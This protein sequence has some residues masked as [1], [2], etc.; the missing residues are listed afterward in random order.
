M[1]ALAVG[2]TAASTLPPPRTARCTRWTPR[3]SRAPSS[4]PARSTSGPSP[5]TRQATCSWPPAREGRIYR[6]DPKGKAQIVLTSPE[7]HILSLAIDDRGNLY[8]GSAPEGIVYRLDP[9]LK[10]FVLLDSRLPRDQGPRDGQ[11]TAAST[12]PPWTRRARTRRRARPAPGG[13]RPGACPGGRGDRHGD[14]RD[15]ACPTAPSGAAARTT[16][17]AP[18]RGRGQGSGPAHPAY[19]RGRHSLVLRGRDAARPRPLGR[20][21]PAGHRQQGQALPGARR[22]HLDHADGAARGA[23]DGARPQP[24]A[25]PSLV[26]TSNPGKLHVDRGRLRRRGGRSPRRSRT[27]RR[28]PCGAAC[29][30]RPRC[31]RGREVQVQTPQRQHRD[32]GLHLDRLVG[33]LPAQRRRCRHQRARALPAD[34]GHARPERTAPRPVLDSVTAAYLQRNLRPQVQSITVHAPGEVFQKPISISGETEI[35]GLEGSP[36]P[37]R[38]GAAAARAQHASGH[39]LQPEAV[40]ARH[41]DVLLEGRRPERRHP[42]LRRVLPGGRAIARSGSLRKGLTDAVL[43]WDTSTVPNGRY[44]IRVTASDSPSNPGRPGPRGRQGEP[45]LRG[46]QHAAQS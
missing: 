24:A 14:L 30:G 7:T 26:A 22:P 1:H 11:P 5:S 44:V 38:P 20:P 27:R 35:L 18:A 45:A 17:D 41:P 31:P 4:T 33:A 23:G 9:A 3:A 19:R 10:V 37:D 39:Q 13:R 32:P 42:R 21:R 34:Q 36:A 43:A 46:R 6:V 16:A 8:A 2:P 28:S 15:A 40:S 12:W 25:A 29:A